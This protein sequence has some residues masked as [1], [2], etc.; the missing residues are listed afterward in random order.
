M[1][2]P[3]LDA[4]SADPG[5][6]AGRIVPSGVTPADGQFVFCLGH[7]EPGFTAFLKP[8]D[9]VEV[10][11]TDALPAGNIMTFQARTRAPASVPTGYTWTASLRVDGTEVATRPIPAGAPV[12]WEWSY[13]L[14][15]VS[16]SH[17]IA[18][19]LT[20]SGPALP[21]PPGL[22][23]IEV[24]IPAFYIDAITFSTS[25]VPV[26]TNEIPVANQGISDGSAPADGTGIDFDIFGE[27]ST[28][29]PSTLHV[30][31]N[32]TDAIVGGSPQPGFTATIGSA[33]E[34]VHVHL[35]PTTPFTSNEL[36]TVVS[37]IGVPPPQLISMS[38]TTGPISGDTSITIHGHNL[39]STT[40]DLIHGSDTFPITVLTN[41]GSTVTGTTSVSDFVGSVDLRASSAGG[42]DT[43]VGAFD[44]TMPT[45]ILSLD[46]T[47]MPVG[48]H[49]PP[50]LTVARA[51]TGSVE[52]AEGELVLGIANDTLRISSRG[53][54]IEQASTNIIWPSIPPA[55]DSGVWNSAA[56]TFG[57]V[58][59]HNSANSPA[60]TEDVLEMSLPPGARAW[61]LLLSSLPATSSW[62]FWIKNRTAD[63]T[64]TPARQINIQNPNVA[65]TRTIAAL[66][67]GSFT[68]KYWRRTGYYEPQSVFLTIDETQND[69][70]PPPYDF[71]TLS[72][73]PY[74]PNV[75][76]WGWQNENGKIVTSYIPTTTGAV[77]RAADHVALTSAA[78]VL[79]GGTLTMTIE[80]WPTGAMDALGGDYPGDVYL[81]SDPN[82]AT[83]YV[84]INT[85]GKLVVSVAGNVWTTA[86]S[87][88]WGDVDYARSVRWGNKSNYV[89]FV[90]AAG[91]GTSS[92]K[93]QVEGFPLVDL[94]MAPTSASALS[95]A[96]ALDLLCKGTNN[97]FTSE[98]AKIEFWHK[99]EGPTWLL[100]PQSGVAYQRQIIIVGTSI[101]QG[102]FLSPPALKV[103]GGLMQGNL[104]RGYRVNNIAISGG[105]YT[106][107]L[108]TSGSGDDANRIICMAK[109]LIRNIACLGAPTNDLAAG[110]APATLLT[111]MQGII[112]KILDQDIAVSIAT[113]LPRVSFSDSTRQTFNNALI[114]AY[115]GNPNVL[116][117]DQGNDPIMGTPTAYTDGTLYIDEVHPTE[118][119]QTYLEPYQ[120]A[121]V[122]ALS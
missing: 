32:G 12:D 104:G 118:L 80:M 33:G 25:A 101:D 17:A 14:T 99:G 39:L 13:D 36:V 30:T 29:D 62:S 74:G 7:D 9:Y 100:F 86:R 88:L 49:N 92:A 93:Y 65:Q 16:G 34:T 45:P 55:A 35:A 120:R 73:T 6:D 19:R 50:E 83:T 115:T 10:T 95:F 82:D 87:V 59:N 122:L 77:T 113:I 96:G 2:N 78:S 94:G 24:E 70:N 47:Q 114:A 42:N 79:D 72:G 119:G 27:G 52:I 89:R 41:D 3:V 28:V 61:N 90:I 67:D 97:T 57:A 23:V 4:F 107:G 76:G 5:L 110:V 81:Y 64:T 37:T 56:G 102:V 51:S 98:V 84:K 8:G 68:Y 112:T 66:R 58:M 111:T 60:G 44:Y 91:N 103:W 121:N 106:N 105:C 1:P 71:A 15:G 108:G 21:G 53:A 117:A 40:F 38:P 26:I 69:T 46:F 63:T 22:P 18:F 43:I 31:V 54:L 75:R 20:F 116:I 11:Q 109:P 48:G 85:S